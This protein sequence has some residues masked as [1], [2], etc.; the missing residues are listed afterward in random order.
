MAAGLAAPAHRLQPT[1]RLLNCPPVRQDPT[2][3]T[4]S[5]HARQIHHARITR[6]HHNNDDAVVTGLRGGSGLNLPTVRRLARALQ[7]LRQL[8]RDQLLRLPCRPGPVRAP[9][10]SYLLLSC[11]SQLADNNLA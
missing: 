8:L 9:P 10:R 2:R 7:V 6:G 4:E 3:D 5:R 11:Q 1:S